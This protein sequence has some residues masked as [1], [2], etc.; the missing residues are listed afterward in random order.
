M[1][2][3][4]S[5]LPALVINESPC[6]VRLAPNASSRFGALLPGSNPSKFTRFVVILNP[7]TLDPMRFADTTLHPVINT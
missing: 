7:E 2:Y 4:R 6:S 1:V 3:G 5:M